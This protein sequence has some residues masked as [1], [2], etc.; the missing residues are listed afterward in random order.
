MPWRHVKPFSFL[1]SGSAPLLSKYSATSQYPNWYRKCNPVFPFLFFAFILPPYFIHSFAIF[2]FPFWQATWNIVLPWW[3]TVFQ[4]SKFPSSDSK[5]SS[6]IFYF[7]CRA[8]ENILFVI[9]ERGV[10]WGVTVGVMFCGV[11]HPE[12]LFEFELFLLIINPSN[13]PLYLGG[14]PGMYPSYHFIF[15]W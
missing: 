11:F 15:I 3:S 1:T 12:L 9:S 13:S 10:P 14:G 7:P 8:Y 6:T 5:H 2:L 4:G